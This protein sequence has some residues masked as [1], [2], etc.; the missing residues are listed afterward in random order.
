MY[1]EL[2]NFKEIIKSEVYLLYGLP[3]KNHYDSFVSLVADELLAR[4]FVL[5]FRSN[6]QKSFAFDTP[7]GFVSKLQAKIEIETA[8]TTKDIHNEFD[9]NIRRINRVEEKERRIHNNTLLSMS[10]KAF[11]LGKTEM[12]S[13]K[14]G[15]R[16]DIPNLILMHQKSEHNS[17]ELLKYVESGRICDSKK[18]SDSNFADAYKYYDEYYSWVK[19]LD[20]KKEYI[21][22]WVNLNR[23]ETAMHFS[24]I[25]KIAEY[26]VANGFKDIPSSGILDFFWGRLGINNNQVI[27]EPYQ[28]IRYDRYIP[29]I[30]NC[31]SLSELSHYANHIFKLRLYDSEIIAKHIYLAQN[32]FSPFF[33]QNTEAVEVMYDFCVNQS[34]LV[35]NHQNGNFYKDDEN[36]ELNRPK[37]KAARKIIEA[38]LSPTELKA[39]DK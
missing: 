2:Q 33:E 17:F 24:L 35:T 31:K 36:K 6:D 30:F 4:M 13:N 3:W 1:K 20:D 8:D 18:V 19:E 34:P 27:L 38:L 14:Q 25:P 12:P 15:R 16:Y 37:I 22:S 28:N 11:E 7:H 21:F 26:M 5:S 39:F 23:C 32:L 10:S 29:R 9:S